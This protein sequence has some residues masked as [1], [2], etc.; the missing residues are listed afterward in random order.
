MHIPYAEELN[1][2]WF[3]ISHIPH[4]FHLI[5]QHHLWWLDIL[6]GVWAAGII[7]FTMIY[8]K[9]FTHGIEGIIVYAGRNSLGLFGDNR[10]I[11]L[12]HN[13]L[14]AFCKVFRLPS[15]SW[16]VDRALW[17]LVGLAVISHYLWF[18]LFIKYFLLSL[19]VMLICY[20]WLW[21]NAAFGTN[22][23]LILLA[24]LAYF[25][26]WNIGFWVFSPHDTWHFLSWHWTVNPTSET[27]NVNKYIYV[28]ILVTS[29]ISVIRHILNH[30]YWKHAKHEPMAWANQFIEITQE[31]TP[32]EKQKIREQQAFKSRNPNVKLLTP[33]EREEG[34]GL[35]VDD[36]TDMDTGDQSFDMLKLLG[37]S[38]KGMALLHTEYPENTIRKALDKLKEAGGIQNPK[39]FF[40]NL[41]EDADLPGS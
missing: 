5:W 19:I 17:G 37:F 7:M 40:L 10:N 27:I 29:Y 20:G 28:L 16:A 4:V 39:I 38:K 15:E 18:V 22:C 2:Y 34:R 6:L 8:L 26:S 21:G 25:Y 41:L 13:P 12:I 24:N 32:K 35:I 14:W 30:F 11:K 3:L 9:K 23:L 1:G 36:N 33:E 31:A